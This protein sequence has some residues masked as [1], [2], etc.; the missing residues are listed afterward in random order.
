MHIASNTQ[1]HDNNTPVS[2]AFDMST[3]MPVGHHPAP[4]NLISRIRIGVRLEQHL[5]DWDMAF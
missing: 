3:E 4:T 2:P 1:T 5:H